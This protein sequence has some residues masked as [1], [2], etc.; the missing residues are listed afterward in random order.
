MTRLAG[1]AIIAALA[2]CSARESSVSSQEGK[3]ASAAPVAKASPAANDPFLAAYP[4][5]QPDGSPLDESYCLGP[6]SEPSNKFGNTKTC[7]M[8]ACRMGDQASCRM[9]ASYNGNLS[10]AD[11]AEPSRRLEGMDYFS[12]RK[13]VLRYG[14]E[15]IAGA[16]E[17]AGTAEDIC[18][19]FPEISYCQGTGTAFCDMQFGQ[20]GQCLRIVTSGGAPDPSGPG[21]TH[22][23]TVTFLRGPCAEK[24][25]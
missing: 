7:F 8:V 1:L 22:V 21:D 2:A 18:R 3:E 25:G 4:H 5:T 24:A 10:S 20:R 6:G 23:E 9:A 17:G 15:P 16:C 13:I 19:R 14:W 12:A 11:M